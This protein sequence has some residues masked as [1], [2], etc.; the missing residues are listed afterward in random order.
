MKIKAI[1]IKP[2]LGLEEI[3]FGADQAEVENIMGEPEEIEDL[4]GE[5]DESDAEV[6]N[7]W[8]EGHTVFFDK[9]QNNRCACF[10]TDN[11][12][13]VMWDKQVFQM[14]EQQITELMKTNGFTELDAEDEEWGERRVSFNDAVV[15]FYF[16]NGQLISVSWGVMI[17]EDT[18]EV[19]WPE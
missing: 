7:Y 5:A 19:K 9:A 18:N 1:E 14:N 11:N 8:K 13:A 12:K 2:L 4:E 16:E 3:K 15:D 17:D 6:W 10:E